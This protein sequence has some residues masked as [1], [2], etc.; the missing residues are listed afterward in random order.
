MSRIDRRRLLLGLAGLPLVLAGCGGGGGDGGGGSGRFDAQPLVDNITD[1]IIV[2][3]YEALNANAGLLLAAVRALQAGPVSDALLDAAQQAWTAA[4]VPWERSEGFLFGPVSALGID[5]AIDSWPLDTAALQAYLASN[6]NPTQADIDNAPDDLRGFHAI[7]YLLFGNGVADN[8]KTA[9]ELTGP[10]VNYLV[11]LTTAFQARTQAL[12]DAWTTA[13]GTTGPYATTLKSPGP[14]S[15]YAS[16]SAVVEEL[17]G[18]VAGIVDEV[19]N[20]KMAEPLGASIGAADTSKV[21]SQYSWNS[22]TDFHDNLQSVMN[23]YTGKLD[24]D[25]ATDRVSTSMNGLYVFVAFHD[26]T[27]ADRVLAEITTAQQDIALIKGD[28]DNTTTAITGTA[29]PFR[30]QIGTVPGRALIETA[31]AAC[32]TLLGTLENDVKPLLARTSFA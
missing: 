6:P 13:F 12:S 25:W 18:G 2:V 7:E 10:E 11:A 19:G 9:S 3:T 29:L 23:A 27:L 31:I 30:T 26:V 28:G 16:Y 24:Y 21:E 20:A 15:T 4:R 5:P 14:G 1:G 17:V 32:N 22:L 8:D